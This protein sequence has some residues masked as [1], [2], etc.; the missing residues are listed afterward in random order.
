MWLYLCLEEL[1][2][3]EFPEA[4]LAELKTLAD[5]ADFTRTKASHGQPIPGV[6]VEPGATRDA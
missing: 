6:M 5:C 3:E 1:C 2:G 4:L